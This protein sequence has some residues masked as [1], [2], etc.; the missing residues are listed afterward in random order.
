MIGQAR[1]TNSAWTSSRNTS[2]SEGKKEI[3][4]SFFDMESNNVKLKTLLYRNAIF[5]LERERKLSNEQVDIWR[6]AL[7]EVD[8]IKG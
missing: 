2:K 5:N 8:A 3:L 7:M 6:E 1:A 4:P